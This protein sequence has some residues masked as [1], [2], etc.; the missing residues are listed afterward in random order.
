MD[1]AVLECRATAPRRVAPSTDR[2]IRDFLAG[3]TD[4]GR[5]LH[6]LYDSVLDEPT[7]ERLQSI[8]GGAE[9]PAEDR[10]DMFQVVIDI[11]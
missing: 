7:P 10:C 9:D 8:F 4:G 1:F 11:E 5:L 6:A 3:K 2:Q